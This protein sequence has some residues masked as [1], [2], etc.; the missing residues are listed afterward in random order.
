MYTIEYSIMLLNI[1]IFIRT[2]NFLTD[3][4]KLFVFIL[5]KILNRYKF[6]FVVKITF[7]W[8]EW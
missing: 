1:V 3:D 7:E 4:F 5:W 8:H 6:D 2:P